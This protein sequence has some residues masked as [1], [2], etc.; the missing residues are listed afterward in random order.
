MSKQKTYS[1]F[2]I[3]VFSWIHFPLYGFIARRMMKSEKLMLNINDLNKNS[4]YVFTVNHQGAPDFFVVFF[5]MPGRIHRQIG[6]YRFFI[7]NK[8]F[9]NPLTRWLALSFGG[10]PAKKHPKYQYGIAAAKHAMNCG[11]S[12]VIFPEGKVSQVDRQHK[13]KQGVAIL[14]KEPDTFIIPVRVK[15]HRDKGIFNSY[16]VAIGKP[17]NGSKMS[18]EEIMDKVY[19]L[20]FK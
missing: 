7:A 1:S 17:F 15:W 19:S 13:P 12:V 8:F 16:D 11:E 6:P 9:K 5:G 10:F 2:Y 14:A 20:K 4:H 18:A 3:L